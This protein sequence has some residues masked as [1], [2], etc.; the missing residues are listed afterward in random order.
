MALQR[1]ASQITDFSVL[2][3]QD[4]AISRIRV[5]EPGAKGTLR[6]EQSL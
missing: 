6:G 2:C 3:Q 1:A 5:G 4:A